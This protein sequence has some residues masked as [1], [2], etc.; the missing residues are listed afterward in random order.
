MLS[1]RPIRVSKTLGSTRIPGSGATGR[2]GTSEQ[3][4]NFRFGL[5]SCSSNI[6]ENGKKRS[7][8]SIKHQYDKSSNLRE[9]LKNESNSNVDQREQYRRIRERF[10]KE[11]DSLVDINL[12]R[13]NLIQWVTYGD[14][15]V[16][17]RLGPKTFARQYSPSSSKAS[18]SEEYIID[19]ITNRKVPK[20]SSNEQDKAKPSETPDEQIQSHTSQDNQKRDTPMASGEA[21]ASEKPLSPKSSPATEDIDAYNTPFHKDAPSTSTSKDVSKLEQIAWNGVSHRTEADEKYLTEYENRCKIDYTKPYLYDEPQE[22]YPRQL[23]EDEKAINLAKLR[24]DLDRQREINK[25]DQ[26]VVKDILALSKGATDFQN[27]LKISRRAEEIAARNAMIE[28]DIK[29]QKRQRDI[30]RKFADTRDMLDARNKMVEEARKARE[31]KR[32][33]D[34]WLAVR[35]VAEK[36]IQVGKTIRTANQIY[37]KMVAN[38]NVVNEEKRVLRVQEAAKN[39]HHQIVANENSAK[40][41]V[42][43]Q[44]IQQ[45]EEDGDSQAV[46]SESVCGKTAHEHRKSENPTRNT[47]I[48]P[49][50]IL[51]LRIEN[52]EL[53]NHVAHLKGRVDDAIATLNAGMIAS[54]SEQKMTGN[55]ARDFPEES[56]V[57]W[58]SKENPTEGLH[59]SLAADVESQDPDGKFADGR[60]PKEAFSR[61]PDALKLETSLDRTTSS[62]Q[63]PTVDRIKRA[64]SKAEEADPMNRK[65]SS[66]VGTIKVLKAEPESSPQPVDE[67]GT[68]A[69]GY[70]LKPMGLE[71]NYKQECEREGKTMGE[72]VCVQ[73]GGSKSGRTEFEG[74]ESK[75]TER[76]EY[77]PQKPIVKIFKA[78]PETNSKPIEAGVDAGVDAFGYSLKPMGLELSY[79]Q[80]CE[81]EGKPIGEFFSVEYGS[82]KA[83]G[84]HSN[85]A[86]K[87]AQQDAHEV[88]DM[89]EQKKVSKKIT[90]EE[91]AVPEPNHYRV[92]VYDPTM[93]SVSTAS[94]TSIVADNTSALTPAEVLLRLSNPAKFLPHFGQLQAQGYEIV[95]GSG[96]VLVF[97][98][99]R[100]ASPESPSKV[101]QTKKVVNP[102]DG[103][104]S[105]PTPATGNFASPTGFVNHDIPIDPPFKSNIDVRREE[106]VFSGTR[107]TWAEDERG[108][109]RS[110]RGRSKRFLLG[111]LSFGACAYAIGVV[112]EFFRTGGSDGLGAV[113][114]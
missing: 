39:L 55:Y 36:E 64:I 93:Q 95:S 41:A 14:R 81:R 6:S 109:K 10:W 49:D 97:R 94:T 13:D 42:R 2:L 75:G 65:N 102:I 69:F 78:E 30:A 114:F 106:P 25:R 70:S 11:S 89:P 43:T 74:Q 51:D 90:E 40:E 91:N 45:K 71:L 86:S 61:N 112:S 38:E 82:S 88:R 21:T 113:G 67:A 107:S 18:S 100:A 83:T 47:A 27:I 32:T 60:G 54:E 3:I 24:Q 15:T 105:R 68:D 48:D 108:A 73:F 52:S 33:V 28:E 9:F 63:L 111:A 98:K 62:L 5:W 19:P 23:T 59:R 7:K 92:L 20:K 17:S 77:Q 101:N 46:A 110:R 96:D 50:R 4:R 44:K 34:N 79:K 1:S 12:S 99:V 80:E 56:K 31:I 29:E 53:Q 103:M 66:I 58:K 104:E 72:V 85:V 76:T 22:W 26:E 84:N 57:S 87:K 37:A 8:H 35:A 16:L